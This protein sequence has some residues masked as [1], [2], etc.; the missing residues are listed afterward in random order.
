MPELAAPEQRG[1]AGGVVLPTAHGPG[2]IG[3]ASTTVPP[4]ALDRVAPAR[5]GQRLDPGREAGGLNDRGFDLV[6]G[7]TG[8]PEA[9][10]VRQFC[11]AKGTDP[12]QG[13]GPAKEIGPALATGRA[14]T[15]PAA[16]TIARTGWRIGRI[17][18]RNA[19]TISRTG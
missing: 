15:I 10:I 9:A 4:R 13:I 17:I 16:S 12:V 14:G 1:P 2:E 18:V 7:A 3:P 6:R 19:A 5:N 8:S 11:L